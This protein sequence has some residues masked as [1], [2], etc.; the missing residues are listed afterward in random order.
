M[1]SSPPAGPAICGA[2]TGLG[3]LALDPAGRGGECVCDVTT[4]VLRAWVSGPL[5]KEALSP[6]ATVLVPNDRRV[7]SPGPATMGTVGRG[8]L[9]GQEGLRAIQVAPARP[10]AKARRGEV[11]ALELLGVGAGGEHQRVPYGAA[12]DGAHRLNVPAD[13][14]SDKARG[15]AHSP[16]PPHDSAT[17][18]FLPLPLFL[19]PP[20]STPEADPRR[21]RVPR[22]HCTKAHR[23]QGW[24]EPSLLS[25]EGLAE[26]APPQPALSLSCTPGLCTPGLCTSLHARPQ[27]QRA[28]AVIPMA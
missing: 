19:P 7:A 13:T 6:L 28:F 4:E 23:R 11:G 3:P 18:G 14:P 24:W 22:G 16:Q 15:A 21:L 12:S 26:A 25:R 20:W 27:P 8:R 5:C 2:W 10:E 17:V 1:S 9:G